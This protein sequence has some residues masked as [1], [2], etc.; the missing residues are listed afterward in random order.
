MPKGGRRWR[1]EL[2]HDP[3]GD[4][5]AEFLARLVD[6]LDHI[7]DAILSMLI[8]IDTGEQPNRAMHQMV[9]HELIGLASLKG[10][11]AVTRTRQKP[12]LAK[13]PRWTGTG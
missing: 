3:G 7:P 5:L 13:P 12:G 2:R 9:W 4:H 1:L 10:P 8:L 6:R 11:G